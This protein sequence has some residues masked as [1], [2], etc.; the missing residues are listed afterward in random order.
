VYDVGK[1]T[2]D[3]M[4]LPL[5]GG[6]FRVRVVVDRPMY[7]VVGGRGTVYET[8]RRADGGR[9]IVA[10]RLSAAGGGGRQGFRN[11]LPDAVDLDEVMC[12]TDAITSQ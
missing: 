2:L 6:I 10:V 3:G 4:P 8:A 11:R 7:E 9:P 5:T 12:P 1:Q